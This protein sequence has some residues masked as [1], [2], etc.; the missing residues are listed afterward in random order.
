MLRFFCSESAGFSFDRGCN[1]RHGNDSFVFIGGFHGFLA[2]EEALKTIFDYKGH[3]GNVPCQSCLNIRNRWCTID[4]NPTL[5]YMWDPDLSKRK[6]T[7]DK[8]I[9]AVVNRLSDPAVGNT[10]RQDMQTKSGINYNSDGLLFDAYLMRNILKPTQNYVRDWMHTLVSNGVAGS[11]LAQLC[12][13]LSTVGCTMEIVQRYASLWAMAHGRVSTDLYFKSEL[14]STD[15]VKHFAS[16]QLGMIPIMY[17]FLHEKILPL[18]VLDK[19][20]ECWTLL[21]KI[22]CVLRR[23]D[24]ND[25]IC[26]TLRSLIVQHN[27]LCLEL[28]GNAHFKVKF[29]HLYH[30]PDDMFWLN[31]II[32]CFVT[33]RKNKDAIAVSV[34]TDRALEKSA[35]ISFLNRTIKHWSNNLE[36]TQE[37]YLLKPRAIML[38][39]QWVDHSTSAVLPCGELHQRQMVALRNGDIGAIVDFWQDAAYK[40]ITVQIE[41]HM[42]IPNE[43]IY[44]ELEPSS[45][46]F[47]SS[48]AINEPISWYATTT[49]LVASMPMYE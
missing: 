25:T 37:S 40:Q 19:N 4:D 24:M 15:H 35:T 27:T 29:H 34:T 33:E 44:F 36:A 10:R 11:H 3:A 46:V 7:T 26:Q 21:W 6:P 8:H 32:S 30:L 12:A 49:K 18:G 13:A 38:H 16:D 28:Y 9:E 14:I 2:D 41:V 17:A 39:G 23:G 5:Q 47:V 43:Q 1:L 45:V 48:H 42:C 22:M 20:I 31:K